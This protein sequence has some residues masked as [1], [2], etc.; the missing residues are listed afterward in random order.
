MN[1]AET[2][3]TA[4]SFVKPA[5]RASAAPKVIRPPLPAGMTRSDILTGYRPTPTYRWVT[6]SDWAPQRAQA[7]D[8][9]HPRIIQATAG[10]CPQ[11][12]CRG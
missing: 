11:G 10:G 8:L 6:S 9:A 1:A 7:D 12:F 2:V 5:H 4:L 3:G